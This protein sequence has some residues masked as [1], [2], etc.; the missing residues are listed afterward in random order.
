MTER[1]SIRG[2]DEMRLAQD[3]LKAFD[4]MERALELQVAII[5]STQSCKCQACTASREA[6]LLAADVQRR[7]TII[8]RRPQE[9]R[10]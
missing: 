6:L 3:R 5:G 9:D 4:M 2:I 7:E 10:P 1:R 8:G